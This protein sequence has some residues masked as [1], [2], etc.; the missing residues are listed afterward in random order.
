MPHRT[1]GQSARRCGS[2]W[3][4]SGADRAAPRAGYALA[5]E[6]ARGALVAQSI[7][8]R[9]IDAGL[10]A[11]LADG[12]VLEREAFVEVFH[13]DDSQIGVQSFIEHGPGKAAFT[14]R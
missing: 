10:S 6:L 8:K 12:L 11:S 3:Q 7:A 5:G 9:V 2:V 1:Q 14:G 4:T 13:T